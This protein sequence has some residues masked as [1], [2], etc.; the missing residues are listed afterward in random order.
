[1]FERI[2]YLIHIP[3]TGG[4]SVGRALFNKYTNERFKMIK[5]SGKHLPYNRAALNLDSLNVI[6]IV[7][8]PFRYAFSNYWVNQ[9]IYNSF[10]NYIEKVL[11]N[12]NKINLIKSMD[13]ADQL[14]A[15]LNFEYKISDPI[16]QSFYLYNQTTNIAPIQKIYRTENLSDFG[17]DFQINVPVTKTGNYDQKIF[18]AAYAENRG[19]EEMVRA[20]FQDDFINFNYSIYLGDADFTFNESKIQRNGA[21][22]FSESTTG[23]PVNSLD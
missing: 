19:T 21:N 7:R 23:L 9:N 4:T 22:N 1:M 10:E 6:S 17:N 5:D 3:R 12:T 11:E 16:I 18:Y 13:P 8:N 14:S 2:P 20:A 15:L